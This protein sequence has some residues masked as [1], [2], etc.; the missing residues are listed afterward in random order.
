VAER[1]GLRFVDSGLMYRAVALVA[2]DRGTDLSAGGD[3]TRLAAELPVRVLDRRVWAGDQELTERIYDKE[4][5]EVVSRI[6]KVAGVRLALVAQ[7]RGLGR[8]GVV[9]AGRDIGTVVFPDAD[10]KFFLTASL[11]ERVRRRSVQLAQRGEAVDA[12][13]M[14]L[15]VEARDRLDSERSVSP[16]RPAEDA[17]IIDT[18]DLDVD[19]VVGLALSRIQ[20][21]SD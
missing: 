2:L 11:E 9:M 1:L 6:A 3:L 4:V 10:F 13:A 16:L 17:I 7:Q 18:D 14:A 15:E 12:E 19:A 8:E 20:G 21:R 5:S